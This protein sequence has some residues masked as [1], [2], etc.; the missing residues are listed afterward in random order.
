MDKKV[1]EKINKDYYDFTFGGVRYYRAFYNIDYL[2]RDFICGHIQADPGTRFIAMDFTYSDDSK[3]KAL[4]PDDDKY[5]QINSA[6]GNPI[7]TLCLIDSETFFSYFIPGKYEKVIFG[8]SDKDYIDEDY[9]YQW[10]CI[11]DILSTILSN[12]KYKKAIL[13]KL[14]DLARE[15][16]RI[17]HILNISSMNDVSYDITINR[18]NLYFLNH[19]E[20]YDYI[21]NIV[22]KV[23]KE[24]KDNYEQ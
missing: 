6:T 20:E 5:K 13:Y 24:V 15:D 8:S 9:K 2:S 19:N 1:I 3:G 12:Q 21:K 10:N 16:K 11:D 17:K 14:D 4:V 7:N 23:Y 22:Y 18:H